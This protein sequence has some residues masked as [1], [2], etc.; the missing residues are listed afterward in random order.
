MAYKVLI[1]LMFI[2]GLNSLGS[3]ANAELS[4]LKFNGMTG[5]LTVNSA[6]PRQIPHCK[7]TVNEN[8]LTISSIPEVTAYR[9][10]VDIRALVE[11]SSE[12]VFSISLPNDAQQKPGPCHGAAATLSYEKFLNI[13]SEAVTVTELYTCNPGGGFQHVINCTLN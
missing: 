11:T 6:I 4:L 8:A 13:S 9:S 5:T 2:L 12:G 3:Q 10:V 7:I 1:L